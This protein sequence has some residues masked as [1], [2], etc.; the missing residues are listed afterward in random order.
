MD[1]DAIYE[2]IVGKIDP[3]K[4]Y[5]DE[6]MNKHTSFKIGGIADF[7]VKPTSIEEIKF[8]IILSKE[9]NI[10]LTIV[11]NG[12]NLLVKD[13]GIRGIVLRPNLQDLEIEENEDKLTIKA[14]AGVPLTKVS[15]LAKEHKATGLE[16]AVGIPGTIGGAV[17]MNAGAYGSEMEKVVVSTKYIDFDGNIVEISNKEH[18]FEYR[19]SVFSTINAIILETKLQLEYGD[20]KQIEEQMEANIKSR[21]EKQPLD[22]PNAGSTFKRG[23]GFITA[24]L[25]DDCGLKGYKVGDA[26]VSTKH[27]GFVINDGKATAKDVLDLTNHIQKEVNN[28]FN[29]NIELEIQVIGE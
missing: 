28:K 27:A 12:T 19:K 13:N 6:P 29:V 7:Y 20:I 2:K 11:G 4:V 3:T 21:T 17:Y 9:E 16:F 10:P 1:L 18:K 22:K 5:R 8:L 23:D 14:G 24:K 26:M 15:K 25:V